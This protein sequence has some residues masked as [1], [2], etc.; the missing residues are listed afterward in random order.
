MEEKK[1]HWEKIYGSKGLHEVSWYERLPEIS[2]KLIEQLNLPED[3]A[4]ID[5]GGG[6]SLLTDHLLKMGFYNLSVLD[7]SG[8]VL[9]RARSRLEEK[10]KRIKWIESNILD[11][12]PSG[13]YDLWHD[14]ATFHFLTR[15]TDKQEYFRILTRAMNTGGYLVI[16]TFSEQGP[17]KCS[18]LPVQQYS[19]ESMSAFFRPVFQNVRFVRYEHHTP[20]N[21]VQNFIYGCFKKE[22]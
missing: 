2:L 18:G 3:S 1:E 14:R 11:F 19:E 7:I 15:E 16:G 5:V 10:A 4:I 21:T 22:S 13:Q 6:D 20:F 9:E 8:V 17:Q 12:E